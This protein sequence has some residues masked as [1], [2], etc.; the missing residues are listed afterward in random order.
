MCTMMLAIRTKAAKACRSADRRIAS[1]P[2]QAL[3]YWRQIT[4]PVTSRVSMLSSSTQN[5]SFCPAL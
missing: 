5:N 4:M 3:K 2:N 1:M